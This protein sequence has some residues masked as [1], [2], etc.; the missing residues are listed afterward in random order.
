MLLDERWV[1]VDHE[2][3][4]QHQ[5]I[6]SFLSLPGFKK[7][8]FF[9]FHHNSSQFPD[10]EKTDQ[11]LKKIGHCHISLLGVGEDGHICGLF[12][13]NLK[14]DKENKSL[15]II[16]KN[17]PKP[18]SPRISVSYSYLQ[19]SEKIFFLVFGPLKAHL[20]KKEILDSQS[21]P[22]SY[23]KKSSTNSLFTDQLA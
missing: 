21:Y 12:P 13:Q 15:T 5:I 2:D 7:D 8:K 18:P 14:D 3:S 10:K 23:L 17:S 16:T 22:F 9:G 1:K 20:L 4:N 11:L 19:K 6:S